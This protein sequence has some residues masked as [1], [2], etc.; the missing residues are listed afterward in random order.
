[1]TGF[2]GNK[3]TKIYHTDECSRAPQEGDAR[4]EFFLRRIEAEHAGYKTCGI[5]KPEKFDSVDSET[6]VVALNFS[7]DRYLDSELANILG[8]DFDAIEAVPKTITLPGA[9]ALWRSSSTGSG[10]T[11]ER[12]TAGK[13]DVERIENGFTYIKGRGWVHQTPVTE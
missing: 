4:R 5:C 3:K 13:Y 1:M 8:E 11:G 6:G 7:L 9:A 2:I 10:L 12:I